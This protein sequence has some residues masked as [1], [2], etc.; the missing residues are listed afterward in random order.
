[1]ESMSK[2]PRGPESALPKEV[3]EI[4]EDDKNVFEI[5]SENDGTFG[6]NLQIATLEKDSE[7]GEESVKYERGYWNF[8][9]R[10][11]AQKV[12]DHANT[13]DRLPGYY[14]NSH[15]AQEWINNIQDFADRLEK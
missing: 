13:I 2:G 5:I 4:N 8:S 12:Y 9:D 1:M 6:V 7:S 14:G 10:E 15:K 11:T 3:Y